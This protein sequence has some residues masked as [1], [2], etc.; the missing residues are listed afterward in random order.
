METDQAPARKS[1]IKESSVL[2]RQDY[3][4]F[5]VHVYFLMNLSRGDFMEGCINRSYLDFNRT[6]H[7]LSRVKSVDQLYR[8][9]KDALASALRELRAICAQGISEDGF[10]DW[11]H[12]TCSNLIETYGGNGYGK[13][14]VGQA[15]KWINMTLKYIFV[16]GEERVGGF[17][18][19]YP[20][21]HMPFDN[22]ILG[23]LHAYGFPGFSVAWSRIGEYDVYL[24]RQKWIRDKFTLMPLDAEFKLWMG[25]EVPLSD[26]R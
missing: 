22:I 1:R 12:R 16:L 15:Q 24:Q 20:F 11:H 10:D 4:D 23:K 17:G 7:G 8:K 2:K 13:F 5:L 6:L 26:G 3:E 9:A 14:S 19:S 25:Q 18:E 21:C